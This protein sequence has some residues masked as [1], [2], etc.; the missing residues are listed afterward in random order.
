[1]EGEVRVHPAAALFPMLSGDE[2]QALAADIAAN[3]LRNPIVRY[4]G[5]ILDGR[6]R[7]AA[8]AIAGV[9]PGYVEYEGDSPTAYVVSAN[10]QRRHLSTSQRAAIAAEV[11]PLFEAEARRRQLAALRQGD[12]VPVVENLPQREGKARDEAGRL[13]DVSGRSVSEAKAIREAAPEVFERVKAGDLSVNLAAQV[14]ELPEEDRQA[15]AEAPREEVREVARDAVRKAHV[16]YNGGNCEWY[17][18]AEIV[19]AARAVL[20]GIDLD[21]AST[22]AANEVVQATT[23]YTAEQDGLTR[24]WAGRVWMNPPYAS[25]L[26]ERFTEKLW[27]EVIAGR[28]EAAC[29][30]TNNATETKWFTTLA[31][32]ASAVCF[33]EGRVKFWSPGKDSA[34][35][36]QGQAVI[37]IGDNEAAFSREFEEIGTVWIKSVARS[38]IGNA[39]LN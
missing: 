37:Y 11:L 9:E 22:E 14:A 36:L 5:A 34:T 38:V 1:M 8:C 33:P 6:N 20:G 12:T 19:E 2:L 30:L 23:Y 3:G 4:E 28:I 26:I 10:L 13:L 16:S 29:V 21:P 18:P 25:G 24:P 17:T 27:E 32:V 39:H 35:P 15:V 7:L 31:S